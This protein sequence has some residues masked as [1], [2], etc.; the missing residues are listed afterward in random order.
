[1]HELDPYRCAV[2]RKNFPNA[3]VVEGD[4]RALSPDDVPS[5][6]VHFF[7]GIGGFGLACEWASWS[8][9]LWTGGFPCQDVSCAG[10]G[11][12]LDGERS[13]LWFERLRLIRA[14]RPVRLLIENVPGLRTRGYDRIHDALDE[15]G[16][17]VR[18]IVVGAEAV[19]APHRRNRVWIVA[20][21]DEPGARRKRDGRGESFPQG[22]AVP[23]SFPHPERLGCPPGSGESG[24]EGEAECRRGEPAG[25]VQ[26]ADGTVSGREANQRNDDGGES[27]LT[28]RGS[29][30]LAECQPGG[31][32]IV[33]SKRQSDRRAPARWPMPPGPAQHE[34]EASR[35]VE[36]GVGVAVDGLSRRLAGFARRNALQTLGDSIVP[37]VA[38]AILRAWMKAEHP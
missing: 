37:Q 11:A 31:S 32:G 2:L 18:S 7:A 36:S 6:E 26:L 8:G 5:G 28:G 12:G 20:Y 38:A 13:G 23:G 29:M 27:N 10:R 3:T 1:M 22:G 9:E 35:L 30:V 19:G 16:Y 14:R 34:W 21:R 24:D 17:A 25:S 15:I 4:I 33:E